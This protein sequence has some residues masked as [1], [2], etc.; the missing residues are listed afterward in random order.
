MRSRPGRGRFALFAPSVSAYVAPVVAEVA[1]ALGSIP[2]R[3]RFALF[4]GPMPSSRLTFHGFVQ[5]ETT[6]TG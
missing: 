4:A 3:R 5:R 2:G 6:Q 1:R